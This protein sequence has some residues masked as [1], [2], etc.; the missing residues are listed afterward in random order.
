MPLRV[1]QGTSNEISLKNT[2]RG[3]YL[4]GTRVY[5]VMLIV[6]QI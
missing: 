1:I 2:F 6:P 5:D 3:N 4:K